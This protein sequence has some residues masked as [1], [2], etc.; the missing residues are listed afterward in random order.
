[1][2]M[3][4]R[5]LA[6]GTLSLAILSACA[7]TVPTTPNASVNVNQ[8]A[9]VDL[10]APPQVGEKLTLKQIMAN[11]DWMG[12]LAKRAYWADDGGSIFFARQAHA[13][14]VTDYY[15]QALSGDA[16][17]LSLSQ[18]HLVD[19]SGGVYNQERTKKAYLYQGNVFVKD[20]DDGASHSSHSSKQT[21]RWYSLF[22]QW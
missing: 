2:K 7:T 22:N 8:T 18:L 4:S 15:E 11:P 17:K 3:L 1:M 19:Q 6:L 5:N 14:P 12:I 20:S 16:K 10:V 9:A 21:Y 13:S